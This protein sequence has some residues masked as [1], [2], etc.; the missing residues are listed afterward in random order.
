MDPP[1]QVI[2]QSEAVLELRQDHIR[3]MLD[4]KPEAITVED[5]KSGEFGVSGLLRSNYAGMPPSQV[6]R[7]FYRM[8]LFGLGG[9]LAGMYIGY[10][11]S[12]PGNI[13]ANPGF[14]NQ[15]GTVRDA[16][17]ALA[18]NAKYVSLWSGFN[19]V[20]QIFSQAVSPIIGDRFGRRINMYLFTFSMILAI[21]VEIV[22]KDWKAYLGAKI[23]IGI[24]CGFLGTTC[25]TYLSEMVMPQMRGSILAAFSFSWQIGSLTSAVGLQVLEQSN[26]LA[27]RRIFYSEFVI[28]GI[29]MIALVLLPESPVWLA[30]K[31][32]DDKGKKALKWLVGNV[33]GYDLDH[34]W[35]VIRSEVADSRKISTKQGSNDWVALFKWKNFRRALISTL[36]FTYQNFIGVPLVFGQTTYFFQNAGLKN[37]FTA[38]VI[39]SC[40]GLAGLGASIYLIERLGRRTLVI[41][42]A[43]I[44][45]VSDMVIGGLG[46]P[47]ITPGLGTG[48]IT[49]SCI[50]MFAY[51]TSLG[52]IGWTALVEISSPVLRAKT[53][54]VAT[55]LQSF[56]GVLFNYT[57]PF[58]LSDQ[59][60]GWGAKIGF[61]FGG[62]SVLYWIPCYFFFPETKN[63]TYAELDELFERD[64]PP[65][66]FHKTI[67]AA[68]GE[69]ITA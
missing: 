58:M 7:K 56:S 14:I 17:G 49:I 57:V 1:Q 54:S 5:T 27:F 32:R 47:K 22:A 24:A 52:P 18:L 21:I 25:V 44:M 16:T 68:Q 11:L 34:E 29:W 4:E 66:L 28:V 23:L 30:M 60:A 6:I 53:A 15:F 45:I 42:G 37:A 2:D 35:A 41:W 48:L 40:I 31:D 69:D 12:A 3:H 63:R 39:I 64:I 19:Y 38:S 62:I 50:W 8:Y 46:I 55:I 59:Y 10:T 65:R 9:G 61:F 36:P 43:A 13:V 20:S 51:Q 67:T 26:P 33:Q